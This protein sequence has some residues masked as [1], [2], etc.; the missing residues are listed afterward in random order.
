MGL[1]CHED[2]CR[3]RQLGNRLRRRHRAL[4]LRGYPILKSK[5]KQKRLSSAASKTGVWRES[6]GRRR[7]T[8]GPLESN[9]KKRFSGTM[10]VRKV[11]DF[12]F[13]LCKKT[14]KRDWIWRERRWRSDNQPPVEQL[15]QWATR[16]TAIFIEPLV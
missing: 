13:S 1:Q 14:D 3:K 10:D 11:L 7:T 12:F 9:E 6:S 16:T 2:E 5:T 4:Q 8:V 15:L